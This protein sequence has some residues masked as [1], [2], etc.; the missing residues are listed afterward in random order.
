MMK[1]I[2]MNFLSNFERNK[3]CEV[4]FEDGCVLVLPQYEIYQFF[5]IE[6][7]NNPRKVND[8]KY[9]YMGIPLAENI[10]RVQS[11]EMTEEEFLGYPEFR[12]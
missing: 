12:G 5:V 8:A 2:F 3:Y 1:G 10:I 6:H 9:Y 4:Y 7:E 11:V